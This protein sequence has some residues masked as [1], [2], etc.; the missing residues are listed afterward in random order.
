VVG[1]NPLG[2]LSV[3]ALLLLLLLQ[4]ATGLMSDDE[5][6]TSGPLVGKVPAAWVQKAT[7]FHTEIG[8]VVLI[9]LTVLHVGAIAWYRFK[10]NEN[11]L[12]AMVSGDKEVAHETRSSRDDSFSRV[13][14]A[15]FLTLCG[16]AVA[17]LI[18]WAQTPA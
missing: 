7:F 15:L 18:W 11:L 17:S 8:K 1:H 2:S 16:L 9:L 14:A 3:L 4:V 13:I 12:T 6:F 10:K 5:V